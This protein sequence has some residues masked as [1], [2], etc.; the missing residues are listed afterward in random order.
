MNCKEFSLLVDSYLRGEL[1]E[2]TKE[3]FEH[4]YFACDKC[5]LDLQIQAKLFGK[6]IKIE[7]TS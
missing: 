6:E 2:E 4:H 5:F 1:S 3:A 7:K